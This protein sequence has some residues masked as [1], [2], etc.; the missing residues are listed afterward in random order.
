MTLLFLIGSASSPLLTHSITGDSTVDS[1]HPRPLHDAFTGFFSD[2]IDDVWN[3]TPWF[4]IAQP[5]GFDFLTVYDYSDVGVLI[6]NNSEASRTIGWAFIEARNIPEENIFIFN[7]SSAPTKETINRDQFDQYFADPFLEMLANRS[8]E[9]ELN[10]LVSTK[11][12]PLRISGG[13]NKASFDQEFSLLGGSLSSSIGSDYWVE[14]GYGPL[15]GSQMEAFS[16][17]QY[18]FFLMTRLTGYTVETALGLIEK[19]NNSLGERGVFA[20]DLATNRNGSGYKFWNDDLYTADGVLNGSMGLDT[21]FDDTTQFMTNVSNVM[22]Y[23]SWGSNDGNWNENKLPNSGFNTADATY[24]SGARY[25]NATLPTLSSGDTFEWSTQSDVKRDGNNAL[26]ASI[27]AVCTQ[28]PGNGTQGIL[29]EFFD[30][31]GVSFSTSSMPTLIDRVPDHVR[32]ESSLQY[33]SSSQAYAGLDNRFQNDWGARFSGLVEVPETGN[34]TFFLTSDD[35]SELWLDGQ[36][37]V[38]NYGSH[39]MREISQY[40]QLDAGKHDFR[41]EFFQGGGPHGLQLS[42][43][44]PNQSKSLIP[45]S[46]FSL[47]DSYIPSEA[48]LIHHW[49]FEDGSGNLAQDSVNTSTSFTLNNMDSSSWKTCVDGSCLWYDGIDDYIDVDVDDWGG[50]FTVSQWVWA[51]TSSL[52]T[53]ASVFAVDNA[54]G[55][56]GSFQH[57]VVNGEWKLHTN[58]SQ[59]FG[60]VQAQEWTHL[61]TV[62]EGATAKQYLDGVLVRSTTY[63]S[64]ALNNIDLYKLGVNRAGSSFFE[65]MIDNVMVWDVALEDHEI[66]TLHRDIYRDCSAYSG[67][68]QSVA[69]IEQTY[70]LPT[71]LKDHAWLISVYGQR[72]GDVYGDF[73]IEIDSFDANGTLIASNQSQSKIFAPSWESQTMRFRPPVDTVTMRVRVPLDIVA[74]STDGSVYLDTMNLHPI[75]PHNSWVNGS[76]AETAVSTGGRSFDPNTAYGQSLIADLLED[77]VSGVKGYVYEPY[78]TAVGS[79][80]ILLSMYAQGFNLAEAHAAANLQTS[81]MGV[82]VG[83]PKMAPYADLHHD[84]NIFGARQLGNASY[85][86]P[87]H[88]QL[89]LENRGMSGSNGS[90]LVQDIQ[91]NIELYNGNISLP[92][93]DMSGSRILY[94]LTVVP[95]KTGWMDLRIRYSNASN[96]SYERN[97]SNNLVTLR[98]WVNAPPVV[99]SIYCDSQVY[100]RGDNFICTVEASDDVNVT[101]VNLEW[102]VAANT[103]DLSNL[104]WFSQATGRIDTLRWQASITLP[105]SL[106]LGTLVLR[107]TAH[108]ISMQQ[109]H[110]LDA[111][112]AIIVDAQAQWFGPH[113]SGVDSPTWSGINQLPYQPQG[114]MYRGETVNWRICALD[115]DFNR[116]TQQPTLLASAG[117]LGNMSY[118][119]QADNTHHCYVGEYLREV[120]TALIDVTFEVRDSSGLLLNSRIISVG[121]RAPSAAIEVVDKDGNALDSVRGGGGEYAHIVFIDTDDPLSSATGDLHIDWPGAERTT[122]PVD[123]S[124]IRNP[125]L[126]ELPSLSVPLETGELSLTLDM[127]GRHGS[128]FTQQFDLPLLLTTPI[129]V[130]AHLCDETGSIDSLRFGQTGYMLVHLQSER[131]IDRLQATLSQLGWSVDAPSLGTVTP[132]STSISSCA[133][134]PDFQELDSLYKFRLR[135]DGTFI[136]GEGQVLFTARDIDGLVRS[137]N[138]EVPFYHAMPQTTVEVLENKSAGELLSITGRVVDQD[139]TDDIECLAQIYQN[140]TVLAELQ[141]SLVPQ[142]PTSASIQFQYPTTGALSNATLLVSTTCTDSW[143]QS[144]RSEFSITLKPEPPCLDCNQTVAANESEDVSSLSTPLLF[145][146]AILLVVLATTVLWRRKQKG[147]DTPLWQVENEG[148]DEGIQEQPIE[149]SPALQLPEGWSREQYQ[150]WLEG[151]MPS[152]WTLLQWMEFTDEQL[153]LLDLQQ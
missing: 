150:V 7:N 143:S 137:F 86:Q 73:I 93:G 18:G 74:T 49:D 21:V 69:S 141:V 32:L 35:G 147:V 127:T 63:P 8:S 47:S 110:L 62:F 142:S 45:S 26:E 52:P 146:G 95:E 112:V 106:S 43:E 121:D 128:A 115:A 102:S 3:Q 54:A 44:G 51:N 6:N 64:G 72:T 23:A 96:G 15:A 11:G 135:L 107:A 111:S 4:D 129:V 30:N 130:A 151:E 71:D 31:N 114:M 57:A 1:N 97:V 83:D 19:A 109:G 17:D 34:W 124:D 55:S 94:N 120:N 53:Y 22:G 80:S 38:T 152:G 28:E 153:E 89:A 36:S 132:N 85:M 122:I 101:S 113:I 139:G 67:T 92:A 70:V 75:L 66:T 125:V 24:S 65:G 116:T 68:G 59:T 82:T 91:G 131:P 42:W 99:E 134:F 33:S 50:N 56:N 79:P 123:A 144:N 40:I 148:S 126:I 104:E 133:S 14:H 77:G 149:G 39:G 25:W 20:L 98:I 37:L 103:T 60:A 10:Y 76:I 136:D 5:G 81:W 118:E 9:T 61:A 41:V 84:I 48:N 16:R 46:A 58:Q 119:Q 117:L 100:A 90:L 13:N 27:S 140:N 78:L 12:T 2:S 145:G 87:S 29:A 105:A 88:I 108:D 138:L